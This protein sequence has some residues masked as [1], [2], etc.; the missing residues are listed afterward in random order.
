MK[1]TM[2]KRF[3][4]VISLWFIAIIAVLCVFGFQLD[5]SGCFVAALVFGTLL[6]ASNTINLVSG[7]MNSRIKLQESKKQYNR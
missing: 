1:A 5:N 3:N 2:I 4:I 6:L 7:I